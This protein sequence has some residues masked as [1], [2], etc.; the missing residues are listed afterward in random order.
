MEIDVESG[1]DDDGVDG[2]IVQRSPAGGGG[3]SQPCVRY[4]VAAYTGAKLLCVQPKSLKPPM[5]TSVLQCCGS[6]LGSAGIVGIHC[7]EL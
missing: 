3:A 1:Q 4:T 7:G 6:E 5:P 2:K